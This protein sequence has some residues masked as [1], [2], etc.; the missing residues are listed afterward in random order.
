MWSRADFVSDIADRRLLWKRSFLVNNPDFVRHVLLDNAENYVR[1]RTNA[2]LFE[3]GM[4]KSLITTEGEEW[5]RQRRLMAPIFSAK[6]VASFTPEF[7]AVATDTLQQWDELADGATL[8]LRKEMS[9]IALKAVVNAIFSAEERIDY[10]KFAEA[11][12][13]YQ[14]IARPALADLVGLPEWFPRTIHWRLRL[15]SIVHDAVDRILARRRQEGPG[16]GDMLDLLIAAGE[17]GDGALTEPEIRSQVTTL[18]ISGHET[19]SVALTWTFYL[20]SQHPEEEIRLHAELQQ[21]L[22]GRVPVYGDLAQLP[23][24]RMIIEETLRLYPSTPAFTRQALGPDRLGDHEIPAGAE[25]LISPY[26]LHRHRRF[27]S[28][29]DRFDPDRFSP[30]QTASRPRFA[31]IPFGA[32]PRICIGASFAMTEA[33]LL[34]AT[35]AQRYRL[36]LAP[37]AVVEPAIQISTFPRYGMPMVIERRGA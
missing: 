31:Y 15:P 19:T 34:L 9:A 33:M 21:V 3:A 14:K 5:R 30:A 18:L 10:D 22:G 1:G 12:E 28:K 17:E 8:D 13:W 6:R 24:T 36:R 7:V 35:I 37:G 27:W 4:G 26:V 29:P 25:L 32:G 16:R 2:R 20:L 11:L 23:R